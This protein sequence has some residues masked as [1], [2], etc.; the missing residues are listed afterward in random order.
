MI[1]KGIE[2]NYFH[3][4]LNVSCHYVCVFA[5]TFLPFPDGF[6]YAKPNRYKMADSKN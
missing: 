6:L 3:L 2:I 1:E 5:A 4:S